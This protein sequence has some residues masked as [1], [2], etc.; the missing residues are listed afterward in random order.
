M[1]KKYFDNFNSYF[2]AL[3][4]IIMESVIPA[5]EII[6]FPCKDVYL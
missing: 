1:I 3:T 2:G 5:P 4:V 6:L